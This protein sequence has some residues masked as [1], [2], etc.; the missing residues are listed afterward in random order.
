[1]LEE[2]STNSI[3]DIESPKTLSLK[4]FSFEVYRQDLVDYFEAHKTV[5]KKMPNGIYSGF[6][7]DIDLFENIPESLVAVVGYPHREPGSNKPYQEIYL[8][9]Q[10]VNPNLPAGYQ[11]LNRAEVLEFLRKNKNKERFVPEWIEVNNSEKLSKLSGILQSWMEVKMKDEAYALRRDPRK[12]L[13][14][15]KA[16]KTITPLDEKFRLENFDLIVWEYVSSTTTNY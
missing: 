9:C 6:M 10:P 7:N 5:F 2:L 3:S 14:E 15:I 4:D 11:E 13:A 12:M 16:G 1:L 8:M